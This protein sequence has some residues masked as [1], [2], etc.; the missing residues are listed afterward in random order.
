MMNLDKT[1]SQLLERAIDMLE[2]KL[3]RSSEIPIQL[4]FLVG[5]YGMFRAVHEPQKIVLHFQTTVDQ[6]TRLTYKVLGQEE[7]LDG[8]T[9]PLGV[10]LPSAMLNPVTS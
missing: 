2:D 6:L 8:F 1:V 10:S 9:A 3:L 5:G 7:Q 4:W